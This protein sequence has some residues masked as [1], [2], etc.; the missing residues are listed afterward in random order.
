VPEQSDLLAPKG[1]KERT[2][3]KGRAPGDDLEFWH[4]RR[5]PIWDRRRS[6]EMN[7]IHLRRMVCVRYGRPWPPK[8]VADGAGGTV[9]EPASSASIGSARRGAGGAA[10][11][12]TMPTSRRSLICSVLR[13]VHDRGGD[14]QSY[15]VQAPTRPP[16]RDNSTLDSKGLPAS[17]D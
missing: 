1:Y 8:L 5:R 11:A 13:A 15:E 14:V 6:D 17:Q 12:T 3:A 10:Q 16:K 4:L 2:F 7:M 9:L